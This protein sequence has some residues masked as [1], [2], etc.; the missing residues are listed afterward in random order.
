MNSSFQLLKGKTD[1]EKSTSPAEHKLFFQGKTASSH[2]EKK[3]IRDLTHI[4]DQSR[5][6]TC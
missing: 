4:R 5:F 3:K 1:G 6:S 2:S